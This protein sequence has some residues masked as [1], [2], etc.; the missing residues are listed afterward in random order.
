[1]AKNT[2]GNTINPQDGMLDPGKAVSFAEQH[3]GHYDYNGYCDQF[4]ENALTGRGGIYGSA[5]DYYNSS[6]KHNA[7]NTTKLP[8]AGAAVFYQGSPDNGHVAV[9]AG[10]GYVWSTGVGGKVEKVPY[11]KLWGG[12]GS[13]KYLGWTSRIGGKYVKVDRSNL[14]PLGSPIAAAGPIPKPSAG[15]AVPAKGGSRVGSFARSA[16]MP[17]AASTSS[18]VPGVGTT[19]TDVASGFGK[20]IAY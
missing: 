9:S 15:P 1:M 8:P 10:G 16:S 3:G 12:T 19:S 4:T 17:G 2:S 13:G 14:K 18:I 7:V 6:V 11:D 5:K 20:M